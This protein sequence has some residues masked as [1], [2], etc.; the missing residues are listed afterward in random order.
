MFGEAGHH[1]EGV[2]YTHGGADDALGLYLKQMGAIPL[3]NREKELS[4]AI[5]L[6]KARAALPPRRPFLLVVIRRLVVMFE[7]IQPARCRSTRRS[8]SCIAWA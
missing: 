1:D 6:E 7:H 5:R 3:L 4:L 2:E 8:T